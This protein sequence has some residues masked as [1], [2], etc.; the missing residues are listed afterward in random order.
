VPSNQTASLSASAFFVVVVVAVVVKF[1]LIGVVLSCF[2]YGCGRR[3]LKPSGCLVL[4]D[5]NKKQGVYYANSSVT[6]TKPLMGEA[7]A[8]KLELPWLLW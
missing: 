6:S 7:F 8:L 3:S 4:D 5:C 2:V 1:W